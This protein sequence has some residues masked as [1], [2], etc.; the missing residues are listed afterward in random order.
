MSS[1]GNAIERWS[2]RSTSGNLDLRHQ[3]ISGDCQSRSSAVKSMAAIV[4]SAYS[5]FSGS[6]YVTDYQSSFQHGSCHVNEEQVS[7]M[8]SEYVKAIYNPS[9][10]DQSHLQQN[11]YCE[12]GSSKDDLSGRI[13]SLKTGNS[14]LTSDERHSPPMRLDKYTTFQQ[15]DQSAIKN[16]SADHVSHKTKRS[17]I[18]SSNLS[19]PDHK[20]SRQYGQ[21]HS[22]TWVRDSVHGEWDQSSTPC[23]MERED[24]PHFPSS[25]F[26]PLAEDVATMCEVSYSSDENNHLSQMNKLNKD[27]FKQIDLQT[28]KHLTLKR[29]DQNPKDHFNYFTDNYLNECATTKSTR[30]SLTEFVS[31]RLRV[32]EIESSSWKPAKETNCY[33]YEGTKS[34][35]VEDLALNEQHKEQYPSLPQNMTDTDCNKLGQW[36]SKSKRPHTR[37]SQT[38][39][40]RATEDFCEQSSK[41]VNYDNLDEVPKSHN[42][43]KDATIKPIPLLSHQQEQTVPQSSNFCE[44]LS[45]KITKAS[46]PMLYHLAGGRN[47][48]FV[49]INN[50][51]QTK[52]LDA[53]NESKTLRRTSPFSIPQADE[54]IKHLHK[55]K[56]QSQLAE[57]CLDDCSDGE[58]PESLTSSAEESF[59]HDYREKLKVAQKKVLRET[60]F[61]RKDLQMSLPVRL[62]LNPSKRP[63]IDHI[64]TY[65]LSGANEDAKFLQP[66]VLADK[67]C[68]KEEPEKSTVSRIGGRKRLSKE[69]RKLCYSEPEKLD[70]L[71]V[72]NTGFAWNSEGSGKNKS[73]DHYRMKSLDKERTLSSSNLS[74]TELKQIQHNALVEYMERKAS[75]RPSSIHQ[76]QVQNTSGIQSFAEWKC[77]TNETVCNNVTQKYHHRRSAGASSS[78]DATVTWNDRQ[79]KTS[80]F[81]DSALSVDKTVN[82]KYKTHFDPCTLE[83]SKCYSGDN[84][85]S[86]CKKRSKSMNHPQVPG[87]YLT[88]STS[89]LSSNYNEFNRRSPVTVDSTTSEAEKECAARGRGK[90]ME[91]IG[92]TD[93]VRL[94]VLSQSTDQLYHIAGP[95]LVPR[96]E[97]T[98]STAVVHQDKLKANTEN[99]SGKDLRKTS[100]EDLLMP[101]RLDV[102]KFVQERQSRS[103]RASPFSHTDN[104]GFSHPSQLHTSAAEQPHT[105]QTDDEV[106]SQPI[107][108]E[109]A[110]RMNP[111]EQESNR[112]CVSNAEEALQSHNTFPVH[113]H[114]EQQVVIVHTPSLDDSGKDLP[115]CDNEGRTETDDPTEGPAVSE[116]PV[117]TVEDFGATSEMRESSEVRSATIP[118]H[119]QINHNPGNELNGTQTTSS[120]FGY[121]THNG[122]DEASGQELE[123]SMEKQGDP[124]KEV[125]S[126][127]RSSAE[128]RHMELVREIISQDKSLVDI[129]KPLPVRESAIN[130]MKS[131][132]PVDISRRE[133]CRNRALTKDKLSPEDMSKLHSKGM[134]LLEKRHS[135]RSERECLDDNTLKK[136]ELIS[137]INL[138][139][140]ELYIDRQLLLSEIAE[141]TT[142]GTKL[143]AV[144]KE[145]CKPNEYE[146][147]MMF[148]GDLE[149]VVSLLFCLSMRLLRVENALSRI[150]EN[151]DADEMSK[152]RRLRKEEKD[153]KEREKTNR[154][155]RGG[156]IQVSQWSYLNQ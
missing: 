153:F 15:L 82:G 43:R 35:E 139:L 73:D 93:K 113:S 28:R 47:N 151:T 116:P 39:Y 81:G 6:S 103:Q 49:T 154:R 4:D 17:P 29:E 48:A 63:S 141:N 62:K 123:A 14:Q 95:A 108:M 11:L 71:G 110:C 135:Q 27:R 89:A 76:A 59:M 109:D 87:G 2:I 10:I 3:L 40:S 1:L 152:R 25:S 101:P 134:L 115:G 55:T 8:D 51:N 91:E 129:L 136:I 18:S 114:L 13:T 86:I 24:S 44:L 111:M 83:N 19:S 150:D 112:N 75:Q 22:P 58:A 74:K 127:L 149:K 9:A 21:C 105:F 145:L 68:K 46:T 131:L 119:E 78:Y 138:R 41:A 106:F 7:Y 57:K 16:G 23:K 61:K 69:Q 50:A 122:S 104:S 94:S 140:E 70:H 92:T 26:L 132:F 148:I 125:L 90:S 99:D 128:E 80:S 79:L 45:D 30:H 34:E 52:E 102:A 143:E 65:S 97:N 100:K 98:S 88:L 53:N 84:F 117:P 38:I 77:M 118:W 147:Y 85:T 37:T 5:S 42:V 20:L 36:D 121:D 31:E 156:D 120:C 144:V 124:A 12:D 56:S 60:S 126:S 137:N 142:H 155:G 146:R 72:C 64:R 133:K 32:Y 66:K 130:L 107:S 67:S 54:P 33:D 96:L